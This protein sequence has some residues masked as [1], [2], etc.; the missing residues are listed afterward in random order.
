MTTEP[1]SSA[2]DGVDAIAVAEDKLGQQ[3]S[4]A[5]A[6]DLQVITAVLN[7][8]ATTAEGVERL[9]VLQDDIERAVRTRTDLDTP[10]GARDFQRFLAGKLRDI[11]T[12]VETADLDAQ[13]KAALAEALTALYAAT[14]PTAADA[15]PAETACPPATAPTTQTPAATAPPGLGVP[16]LGQMGMPAAAGLPFAGATPATGLSSAEKQVAKPQ[17]GERES[18]RERERTEAREEKPEDDALTVVLPD[19]ERIT[20]P[21][22]EVASAIRAVLDGAPIDET[23]QDN[24]F[25]LP[26]PDTSSL[27]TA[28]LLPG[29]V[30]VFVDRHGLALGHDKAYVDDRIQPV[31]DVTGP[32]FLGWVRPTRATTTDEPSVADTRPAVV[33]V[34]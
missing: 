16:N 27:P 20:A 29:D 28:E 15:R 33:T 2:G 32:A 31:A 10:V 11:Q 13:S 24:G 23:F 12:V 6:L 1:R 8:H 7:A 14:A 22:R 4:A 3:N 26:S 25:Q 17:T 30:A 21:N 18:L 9:A 5:A 19:G 34:A